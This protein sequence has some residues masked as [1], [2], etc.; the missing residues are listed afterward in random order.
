MAIIE[1]PHALRSLA[2]GAAK[3]RVD[4]AT[5][6][7]ALQALCA[8]HPPLREKLF[9]PDGRLRRFLG[10]FVGDD[11][12]R[13]EPGRAVTATDAITLIAAISGG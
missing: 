5:V 13:D 8:T 12:V 1:L 2:G 9:L 4:A 10:V 7:D 6:G 3:V 11:D